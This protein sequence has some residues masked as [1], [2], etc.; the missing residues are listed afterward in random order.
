MLV[1]EEVCND[2]QQI[3]E[4]ISFMVTLVLRIT[5]VIWKTCVC[6]NLQFCLLFLLYKSNYL[7]IWVY[8][9]YISK[10]NAILII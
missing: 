2:H 7:L 9:I 5:F 3:E 6:D 4:M 10:I 1:L 8:M